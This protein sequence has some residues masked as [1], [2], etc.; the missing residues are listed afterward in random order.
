MAA[1]SFPIAYDR[2]R[3]KDT[4][5]KSIVLQ[6]PHSFLRSDMF[7]DSLLQAFAHQAIQHQG[8]VLILRQVVLLSIY[9]IPFSVQNRTVFFTFPH[10]FA[11]PTKDRPDK[12]QYSHEL[13][14]Q[15]SPV[16]AFTYVP[17]AEGPVL[18]VRSK[19]LPALCALR[20]FALRKGW[21][22]DRT[23]DGNHYAS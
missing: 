6:V 18:A 22:F 8:K 3:A 20:H 14:P 9:I 19:R 17:Y 5:K 21:S 11:S 12:T 7:P 10:F 1:S 13:R 2:L 16:I 23:L 4:Q 15:R